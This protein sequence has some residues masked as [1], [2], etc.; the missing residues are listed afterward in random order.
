MADS[1]PTERCDCTY[2]D[3]PTPDGRCENPSIRSE[4]PRLAG[5]TGCGCCVADC[6]DVHPEPVGIG[7]VPGSARVAA[8]Y[9]A[10][11]PLEQQAKLRE[12]E[13]RG[14][15]RIV[16]R[17]EMRPRTLQIIHTCACAEPHAGN[18]GRCDNPAGPGTETRCA[19]CAADVDDG[20]D[21]YTRLS[22]AVEAGHYRVSGPAEFGQALRDR[23]ARERAAADESDEERMTRIRREVSVQEQEQAPIVRPTV[24]SSP[25]WADSVVL[26][27]RV[28]T[29]VHA[30]LVA[31]AADHGVD[32]GSAA[33]AAV[34]WYLD[35]PDAAGAPG[36]VEPAPPMSPELRELLAEADAF[37]E[38][39]L[40][41]DDGL[42]VDP[43]TISMPNWPGVQI[44]VRFSA[45]VY[46][47]LADRAAARNVDVSDVVR[48][49]ALHWT[50]RNHR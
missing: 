48:A 35:N 8:E 2:P 20:A 43:A 40:V 13:A 49:A 33:R 5:Y 50:R 32:V 4:D 30:K 36:P 24:L 37:Y 41:P 3:H 19:A 27:V 26:S 1:D 38:A 23:L 47:R 34:A 31:A 39:S 22:R 44:E 46:A 6:L 7:V 15:L 25:N 29:P 16:P 18:S 17:S 45:G 14:E 10:T 12:A 28:S 11:L 9:V 42:P 21:R